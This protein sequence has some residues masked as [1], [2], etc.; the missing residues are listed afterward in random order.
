MAPGSW[1]NGCGYFL[2]T[3]GRS[4]TLWNTHFMDV[5]LRGMWTSRERESNKY[6][7]TKLKY[8]LCTKQDKPKTVSNKEIKFNS[9]ILRV[10]EVF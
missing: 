3:E 10:A 7:N 1:S 6:I 2:M 9:K 8:C 4:S 5:S